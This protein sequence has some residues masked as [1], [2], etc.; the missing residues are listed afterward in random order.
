[1]ISPKAYDW[2]SWNLAWWHILVLQSLPAVQKLKFKKSKMRTATILKI[3]KCDISA[4]VWPILIKFGTTMH[5]SHP[6]YLT[7]NQMFENLKIQD[8]GRRPSWK[9]KIIFKTVEPILMKFCMITQI[10][11]CSKN[12]MFKPKDGGLLPFW[13]LL[14]VICQETFGQFWRNLYG[15]AH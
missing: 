4:T 1:M 12:Q 9:S 3:V 13:K 6:N 14:D 15:D 7:C 8:G 2:F 11:S 10:S 5:I